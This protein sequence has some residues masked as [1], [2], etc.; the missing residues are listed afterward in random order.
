MQHDQNIELP[1]K[2]SLRQPRGQDDHADARQPHCDGETESRFP[3]GQDLHVDPSQP[4]ESGQGHGVTAAEGHPRLAR[5]LSPSSSGEGQ[6]AKAKKAKRHFPTPDD[7]P[8]LTEG[9]CRFADKA[10]LCPPDVSETIAAIR[11]AHRERMFA[12]EQRK[13]A[14]L[15]LGSFLRSGLGWR[16]D[17]DPKE[18]KEIAALATDLIKCGEKLFKGKEHPLSDSLP[19]VKYGSMITASIM[20]RA[21]FD[22]IESDQTKNMERLAM[23][24]PVWA[25]F[26]KNV[27]GF[28]AR[29]LAVIVGEAGD[30]SAYPKKGHL[31]KRMGVAVMEGVRQGG[32]SK[33]AGAEAWIAHG[34]NRKRRSQMFI[35][36]DVLVKV[37]AHYRQV[38]LDRKAF[39]QARAIAA[40]LIVAPAAKIPAKRKSEFICDGHIHR[41]AQRYMEKKLLRD[42]RQAWI[43]STK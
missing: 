21:P 34:Y 12:M 22:G 4:N 3:K 30:L 43:E 18:N 26:G 6:I 10:P 31:W 2:A 39:E 19:W 29:S 17:G 9:Q 28:G 23:Q 40:G 33:S 16:R 15:A 20:A 11:S 36:G 37:G 7:P 1:G 32:L 24:L 25:A 41:R 38:Y 8:S 35:I 27:R 13:R 42:L 14:D 5:P